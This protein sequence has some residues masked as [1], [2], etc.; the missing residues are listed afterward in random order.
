MLEPEGEHTV[1]A[2]TLLRGVGWLARGDL[3]VIE[4]A[5]G[6]MLPTPGAQELG[7]HRFEYALLL[8][9]GNWELGG[10]LSD[11]Q[12]YAAPPRTFAP[13][14][15]AKV[16]SGRSLMEVTP[17]SLVVLAAYPSEVGLVVRLLNAAA[18]QTEALVRP[19]FPP[20]ETLEL[21]PLEQ[22]IEGNQTTSISD[23]T[24]RLMLRPWQIVTLLVRR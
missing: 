3:S 15:R 4:H 12:R 1:V 20:R 9:Q 2:L 14:H 5:A 11:A 24:I 23:G 7:E 13:G 10:V 16:A 8:H 21:N 18:T 6:P 19:A 22:P 17:S